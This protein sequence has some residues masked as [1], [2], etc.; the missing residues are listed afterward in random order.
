VGSVKKNIERI[1]FYGTDAKY[2]P[3]AGFVDF[4]NLTLIVNRLPK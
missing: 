3:R 2:L 4:D 1:V